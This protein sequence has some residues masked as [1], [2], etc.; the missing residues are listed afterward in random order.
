MIYA[1]DEKNVLRILV[2]MELTLSTQL[3]YLAIQT[4]L[5]Q[6]MNDRVMAKSDFKQ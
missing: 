5:K 6:L 4:E 1:W 2:S 3:K